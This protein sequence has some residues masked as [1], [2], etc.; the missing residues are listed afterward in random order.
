MSDAHMLGPM[1]KEIARG[2]SKVET[3]FLPAVALSSFGSMI[4]EGLPEPKWGRLHACLI[5]VGPLNPSSRQWF[6]ARF[7]HRTWLY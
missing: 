3:S 6:E 1:P 4:I 5:P 7:P 2:T